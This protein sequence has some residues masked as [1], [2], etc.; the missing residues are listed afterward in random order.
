MRGA[1][2][3][4]INLV[5]LRVQSYKNLQG[6]CQCNFTSARTPRDS[7]NTLL[8]SK[9]RWGFIEPDLCN[10]WIV[11]ALKQNKTVDQIWRSYRPQRKHD[12]HNVVQKTHSVQTIVNIIHT[13]LTQT[14]ETDNGDNVYSKCKRDVFCECPR[15]KRYK[16][17]SPCLQLKE[18]SN[19][20]L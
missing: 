4:Y 13:I 20:P 19:K 17:G 6:H 7:H 12:V 18:T 11:G 5:L 16:Y 1:K 14:C 10:H 8:H 15:C 9:R 3:R 2:T